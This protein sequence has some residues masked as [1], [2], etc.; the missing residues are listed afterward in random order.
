M[1]KP[2]IKTQASKAGK[3][4]FKDVGE[5][6]NELKAF[7]N[8]FKVI[9]SD[10]S[11]RISDYFE[12]SCFNLVVKYYELSGYKV[13]PGNIIKGQY[14]YKCSPRGIQSNFSHFIASIG[15]GSRREHFEIHHNLPLQSAHDEL[16]FAT[17]DIAVIS[18]ES[19][20]YKKDYYESKVI[21]SYAE[22][23]DVYA[24]CEAKNF[25]PFPELLF[26]FMGIVNELAI[27]IISSRPLKRRKRHIAPSLM[28]SGRA[29][30]PAKR[31]KFSLESRYQVNILFDLFYTSR[32][33]IARDEAAFVRTDEVMKF[34]PE[35]LPF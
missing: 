19:L 27:D 10:H 13:I 21:F 25:V 14:R 1:P 7:S 34:D 5:F 2:K 15:R 23:E 29:G 22:N 35:D 16:V 32:L 28:V 9:I 31:I 18:A 4:P 8:K 30:A 26:S 17:P 12:I 24:F 6:E 20:K 11:R 33:Y 3:S